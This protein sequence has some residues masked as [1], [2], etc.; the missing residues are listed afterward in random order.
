MLIKSNKL[1]L[2]EVAE[3]RSRREVRQHREKVEVQWREKNRRS[4]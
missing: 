3:G 1:Y 2:R 4:L